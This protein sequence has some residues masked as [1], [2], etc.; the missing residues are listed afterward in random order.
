MAARGSRRIPA[1]AR[2]R[3]SVFGRR[4]IASSRSDPT[5]SGSPRGSARRPRCRLGLACDTADARRRRCGRSTPSAS[6]IARIAAETS[7]SSR[8]DQPRRALDHGDRGAEAAVHLRKLEADIAAAQNDQMR[9]QPIERRRCELLVR[10]GTP[11]GPECPARWRAPPT[12]M[13]M[14]GALQEA[15]THAQL[16]RHS[17]SAPGRASACTA[18]ICC[19]QLLDAVARIQRHRGG[20]LAGPA[21]V[22]AQPGPMIDAVLRR[23][24]APAAPRRHWPPASWSACSRY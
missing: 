3:S 24:G 20:P 2:P 19:S 13:K 16:R 6:R 23:P 4:P 7:G 17:R 8:A 9:R 21:H 15:L 12:L 18:C 11:A 22:D 14:R 10:Y 5:I 1:A